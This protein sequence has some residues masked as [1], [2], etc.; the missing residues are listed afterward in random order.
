MDQV[1]TGLQGSKLF[2]YLDDTVLYASSLREYGIKFAKL[3]NRLRAVNLKLQPDKC[4]FL[5]KEVTYLG[6]VIG[7][8]GVKP[9]PKKIQ[10]MK[11]LPRPS[12]VKGIKQFLGLAGYYRCFIPGFSK[13]A[14]PLT[15][16]LKKEIPFEW[17]KPQEDAFVCLRDAL[18]IEP[19]LQ[20][21]DF[22]KPFVVTT[23]A[24]G[25]A[26]GGILSQA[27]IG[28]DLLIAYASRLLNTAEQNYSTIKKDFVLLEN[29][30]R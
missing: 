8:T 27:Q 15:G 29:Y 30:S 28:K 25:Y 23:D 13:L 6:H 17:E 26:I 14:K 19:I 2:V 4:E 12:N 16:L 24:L 11:D 3:A 21:P 22:T 18:C 1:L 10:A 20:Y 5:R 9:D 7:E